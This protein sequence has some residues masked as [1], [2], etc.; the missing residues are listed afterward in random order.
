MNEAKKIRKPT[1]NPNMSK[2][3]MD[4]LILIKSTMAKQGKK[5][6]DLAELFDLSSSEISRKLDGGSG[7]TQDQLLQLLSFLNVSLVCVDT[8]IILDRDRYNA[9]VELAHA[10]MDDMKETKDGIDRRRPEL[11]K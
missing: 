8:Q 5:Q 10:Q 2:E 11:V 6:A 1:G 4:F 9:I 7:F 3:L